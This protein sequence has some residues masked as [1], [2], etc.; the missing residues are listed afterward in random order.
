MKTL[1]V[2]YS[3]HGHAKTIAERIAK[4]FNADVE[5]VVDTKSR[6]HL[7]SWKESAFDEQL[8]TPTHIMPSKFNPRN[9]DL[10]I[11]GTPIWDGISPPIWAYLSL[12]KGKFKKTAFFAT[13]HAAAE[14]ACYFMGDLAGKKPLATLEL[15]DRQVELGDHKKIIEDFCREIKKK[16][17]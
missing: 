3:R 6:D 15:Q 5:E 10:V 12:N 11:V 2:Y 8:R 4:F 1:V 17:K 9:Y 13:F 7:I 16:A 14:N